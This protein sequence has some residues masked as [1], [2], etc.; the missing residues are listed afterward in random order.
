MKIDLTVDNGPCNTEL[1]SWCLGIAIYWLLSM[2]FSVIFAPNVLNFIGFAIIVVANIC[3][4]IGTLKEKPILVFVWLIFA[5]IEAISF[6]FA[7]FGVIFHYGGYREATGMSNIFGA[8]FVYI[9]TFLLILFSA[10]IVYSFYLQ[11]KNSEA[12]KQT[13]HAMNVV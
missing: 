12:S 13:P 9:I 4:M 8:L 1:R 7:I 10:R 6:P 2:T 11:L 3:L 5:V